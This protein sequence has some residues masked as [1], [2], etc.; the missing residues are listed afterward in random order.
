M[1]YTTMMWKE[2][3]LK[4]VPFLRKNIQLQTHVP[5]M[6]DVAR[7]LARRAPPNEEASGEQQEPDTVTRFT[8]SSPGSAVH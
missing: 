6:L 8:D 2:D 5:W 7:S 4:S 1:H 3:E